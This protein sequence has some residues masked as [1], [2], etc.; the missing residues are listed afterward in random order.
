MKI[1]I[2]TVQQPGES[3]KRSQTPFLVQGKP[4][5]TPVMITGNQD[6]KRFT[7]RKF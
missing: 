1:G 4:R 7:F 2:Y 5:A 6:G 3:P